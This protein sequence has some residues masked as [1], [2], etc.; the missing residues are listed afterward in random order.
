MSDDTRMFLAWIGATVSTFG[1]LVPSVMW[2]DHVVGPLLRGTQFAI[3][4]ALGMVGI[5]IG[6]VWFWHWSYVKIK[7]YL[8]G[9]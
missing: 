9:S 3:F 7:G 2:S 1:F 4:G 8:D 6:G 5:A